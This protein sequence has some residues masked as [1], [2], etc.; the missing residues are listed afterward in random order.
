MYIQP[1]DYTVI[2]QND[3]VAAIK[4]LNTNYKRVLKY[5]LIMKTDVKWRFMQVLSDSSMSLP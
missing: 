3:K 5:L 4:C 2:G 1:V